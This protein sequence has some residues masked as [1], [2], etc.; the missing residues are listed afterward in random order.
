MLPLRLLIRERILGPEH[1]GT[2]ATRSNLTY[3][4]GQADTNGSGNGS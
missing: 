4:T 1:P 2:L 3:R